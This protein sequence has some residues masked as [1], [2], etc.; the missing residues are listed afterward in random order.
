V[1]SG[2]PPATA[3]RSTPASASR[4]GRGAAEPV[5]AGAAAAGSDATAGWGGALVDGVRLA[6]RSDG[7]TSV[8]TRRAPDRTANPQ[9]SSRAAWSAARSGTFS[10]FITL[11]T[12]VR[13]PRVAAVTKVCRA[14]SVKP[15]L[16]PRSP[17]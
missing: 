14:A 16:P 15:V 2:V 7:R 6:V 5:R 17:G 11:T 3:T 9:S 8:P 12:S 10:V 4:A 13:P 1:S